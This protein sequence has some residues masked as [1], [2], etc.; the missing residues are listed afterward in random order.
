MQ[1]A[2]STVGSARAPGEL[3]QEVVGLSQVLVAVAVVGLAL[4]SAMDSAVCDLNKELLTTD[5]SFL[6]D[7]CAIGMAFQF[8]GSWSR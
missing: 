2:R 6:Y 3:L 8:L 1:L 7:I 4:L 5:F